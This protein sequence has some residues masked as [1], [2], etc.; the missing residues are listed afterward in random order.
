LKLGVRKHEVWMVSQ[1]QSRVSQFLTRPLPPGE[2]AQGNTTLGL[3]ARYTTDRPWRDSVLRRLTA[4]CASALEKR[5][6]EM[7]EPTR[8]YYA[9]AA[10]IL[11]AILEVTAGRGKR[12]GRGKG[13]SAVR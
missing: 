13:G 5:L 12:K 2:Q 9:E 4:G 6:P 11:R 3:I 8:E 1:L 7:P 10:A